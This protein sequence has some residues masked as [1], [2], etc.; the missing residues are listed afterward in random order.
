MPNLQNHVLEMG[1]ETLSQRPF[2]AA[3]S[4]VL[5]Q[6][7]YMPMEGLM[8]DDPHVTIAQLS[9]YLLQQYPD[10]LTDPFQQKRYL[11]T[12]ACGGATR[13]ADWLILDYVNHIDP[14]NETQFCA[15]TFVLPN[16][17][18]Y[19]AFRGT[20][21]SLAGWKEDLNMSFKTVPAQ[22]SAIKYV[23]RA[24]KA[25]ACPL[26]LGGHSKGG[27]LALYAGAH[28]SPKTQAR[29]Q[30]VYSFDGPGVDEATLRSD[31]Y[32]RISS[33]VVSYIPQSS[34][35]GMLL[36]YH[37]L[38]WVVK[39]NT[40]GLWQHDV[41]TWQLKNGEFE[42]LD[43]LDLGTRLTDEALRLWIDRLTLDDRQML[44]DTVFGMIATLDTETFD[45]VL[46]DIPGSSLK[47]LHAFRKLEP[48]RRTH[49]VKVM[50]ELFSS[51]ASEA[52]RMLLPSA[53]RHFIENPT[54]PAKLIEQIQQKQVALL[55]KLRPT[56]D[57]PKEE[58]A[59]TP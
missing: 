18:R 36:C 2:D 47:L 33:R 24:A 38:Y 5:S 23:R 51:G 39:S 17:T 53:L 19:I 35:V 57:E 15:C 55:Q 3:D 12:Q 52:V 11:L 14:T 45:P 31:G 16:D 42:I 43:G 7:V 48:E 4:M 58:G 49:L 20:D 34:V 44:T 29:I 30:Q 50:G 9:A 32:T 22:E 21:L 6:I 41:L 8:G 25:C 27:H 40:I 28:V 56:Q 26:L 10:G 1:S 46:Q 13:Y 37:P 59:T 54:P